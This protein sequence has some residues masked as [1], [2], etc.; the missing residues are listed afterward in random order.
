MMLNRFTVFKI[1]ALI[2]IAADKGILLILAALAAIIMVNSQYG[3]AYDGFLHLKHSLTIGAFN[4]TLSTHELVNDFFMAIFFFLIGMEV[5]REMVEGELSERSHKTLPIITATSGVLVPLIIYAFFNHSNEA[6]MEGWAIPAATDIAFA[7]GVFG[8]FGK[9]LPGSLRIFLAALAI[10]DDLIAVVIIAIF[11]T[12]DLVYDYLMYITIVVLV[13]ALLNYT[14][15]YSRFLFLSLGLVMWYFFL[16]SGVHATIGGVVLG[17]LVPLSHPRI[18]NRSPLRRLE[19][20]FAPFVNLFILPLFAFTNSGLDLSVVN[21]HTLFHPI[22]MG[23]ALGLFFGKQ[24]GIFGVGMLAIKLGISS[25]PR[26]SNIL[27]FYGTSIL[28]G[29]GFT[30]SLFIGML[31]FDGNVEFMSETKMG[32]LL[33]SF[34][35]A[36]WGAIVLK[37]ARKR[38]E[39]IA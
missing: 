39:A 2:K 9:G 37:Y 27:Q 11:Y 7:L 35:S 21:M 18:N 38:E 26:A 1:L 5:K 33:G 12:G 30:M 16:K 19:R 36:I 13:L 28:C 31:A 6:Y 22:T 3:M 14:R 20:L 25:M 15:L 29:I 24:I 4:L 10:I 23:I 8:L 32:V 34:L 17:L